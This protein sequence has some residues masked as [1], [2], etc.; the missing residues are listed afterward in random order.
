MGT[1][2]DLRAALRRI[3]GRGYKAYQ[4]LRGTYRF[5]GGWELSID[6]VQGDPFAAPSRIRARVPAGQAG[7]PPELWQTRTR[8]VALCDYVARTAARVIRQ[9]ARGRR[10]SGSSGRIAVDEPGQQVLERTAVV[11]GPECAELRLSVGLPAQGRRVLGRAAEEM[12][13]EELPRIAAAAL[14]YRALDPHR[15]RA[16]VE[17]AEDQEFI[18]GQLRARGLVAFVGDGAILPRESGV[19][20]RPMDAQRAVPFETPPE[21]A[22]EFAVPHRG[23][24]RGMGIPAGVTLIAG[25]GYHGKT[26]L[27]R[28]LAFGVYNHVAGD[29]REWVITDADAVKIRAED[30]RRVEG[31]DISPF[32]NRLPMGRDTRRFS[33][34]DASGSTSQAANIVEALEM[35][36]R[37]LLIDEDTSATNFMIRDARMQ[38]LVAREKEPITPFIDRV[39]QLYVEHGVSSVLVVGGA[40]DYLDVADTVIIMDEYRPRDATAVA[41]RIAREY[42]SGRQPEAAGPFGPVR[43]RVPLP[44]TVDPR[45]SGKPRARH[46]GVDEIAFGYEDIDLRHIE[47]IVHPSQT[48]AIAAALVYLAERVLDGKISIREA[49]KRVMAAIDE[50]GLDVI[51]PFQGHPG[52]YARPRPHE[53]AAALNRLRTLKVRG[54]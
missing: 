12:L 25:G 39:R 4:D 41:R 1:H 35:G 6:H 17:L 13:L 27:L 37:V 11:I 9:M 51:S 16:H 20:D 22:V 10:G 21:L 5:P 42:P 32:I 23:V 50:N 53:V 54:G 48:A 19:S 2:E 28:A 8:R 43:S 34:D 36:C 15:V 40:G 3:D 29:G 18:R 33:S 38:A 14:Y 44:Q 24:V 45:R 46:R 30:G 52:D 7:F 26:T 47:Q 49:V 31:V